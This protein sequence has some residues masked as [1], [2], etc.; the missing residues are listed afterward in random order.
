MS[1]AHV[2]TEIKTG[3]KRR[4]KKVPALLLYQTA[5]RVLL[6]WKRVDE[7]FYTRMVPLR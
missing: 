3:C 4:Q 1:G 5:D 2:S 6:I 7:A